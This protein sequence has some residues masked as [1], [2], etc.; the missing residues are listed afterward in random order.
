M[1]NRD[2]IS[3]RVTVLVPVLISSTGH[4]ATHR[5]RQGRR[6]Q[7]MHITGSSSKAKARIISL[8]DMYEHGPAERMTAPGSRVG[9]AVRGG[10]RQ[11][12]DRYLMRYL[13]C[14]G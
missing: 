5:H 6:P 12:V 1:L 3:P 2:R 14:K 4:R 13:P 11:L 8:I 10:R 9:F 7:R